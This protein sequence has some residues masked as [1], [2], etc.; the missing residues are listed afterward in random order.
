MPANMDSP[1]IVGIVVPFLYI[2]LA[3]NPFS[4]AFLINFGV[5]MKVVINPVRKVRKI[6][7]SFIVYRRFFLFYA[8]VFLSVLCLSVSLH[9]R[10]RNLFC[11][12]IFCFVF[13]SGLCVLQRI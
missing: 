8:L 13:F 3:R 7:I 10:D 6:C 5:Y 12:Y 2:S 11:L 1:P 9:V 4:V